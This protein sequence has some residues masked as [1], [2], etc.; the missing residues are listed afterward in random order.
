MYK[1]W[2]PFETIM[3][4]GEVKSLLESSNLIERVIIL[5]ENK[6]PGTSCVLIG[7]IDFKLNLLPKD[8]INLHISIAIEK[9]KEILKRNYETPLALIEDVRKNI[10]K[11]I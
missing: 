4:Y 9:E 11:G 1:I 5:E 2:L 7:S 10:S 8:L 6:I 3:W